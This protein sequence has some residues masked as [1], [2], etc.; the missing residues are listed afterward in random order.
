MNITS[1]LLQDK[2]MRSVKRA[3]TSGIAPLGPGKKEKISMD[4]ALKGLSHLI[5][6]KKNCPQDHSLR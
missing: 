3:R 5:D 6:E 1:K 4:V 2:V